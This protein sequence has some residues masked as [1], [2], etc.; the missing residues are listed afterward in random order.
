MS[1]SVPDTVYTLTASA[2]F[3]VA[4]MVVDVWTMLLITV[5]EKDQVPVSPLASR[6]VPETL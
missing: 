4:D 6:S 5:N 3:V 2:P 1:R